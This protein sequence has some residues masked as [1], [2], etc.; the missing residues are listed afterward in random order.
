MVEVKLT[1]SN[2]IEVRELTRRF[3]KFTAVDRI[4]FSVRKGEIFGFLGP[5]GAGKSTTIRM[6]CGLLKPS[7]GI[8]IV[9]GYD[10][11]SEAEQVRQV[12]GYMSQKFSLYRDLTALENLT[13][14][15]GVYGL[16]GRELKAR[17]DEVVELIGLEDVV[18]R[19]SGELSGAILQRLALACAI[20]HRPA[21]LF[22]DEPTSGVDPMSRRAFWSLIQDMAAGGVTIM[23][24]THFLDEAEFC[25]RIAFINAG[26]LV[27]IG[28]PNELKTKSLNE[29]I[30]EVGVEPIIAARER[31]Q[32]ITGVIDVS[33]FGAKLH[34]FCARSLH[35]PDS[36][37]T[38]IE[39]FGFRVTTIEQIKPGLEDVFVRLAKKREPQVA[40]A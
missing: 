20:V 26:Q 2:A 31:I 28:S 1:D 13:F 18:E 3:G 21:I 30:F 5:N 29:D 19:I 22:L 39:K 32:G 14:Y 11:G 37:K 23:V 7:S 40:A 16:S 33:W 12:I 4:S 17:I 24:T 36:L 9:G 35:S 34:I 6:L 38:E 8:A 10:V 25:E 15:G 27:A